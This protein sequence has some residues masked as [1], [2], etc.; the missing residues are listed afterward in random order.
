MRT[1]STARLVPRTPLDVLPLAARLMPA[2][3]YVHACAPPAQHACCHTDP[4]DHHVPRLHGIYRKPPFHRT[5]DRPH[6]SMDRRKKLE[7]R[8]V[9]RLL[10]D[11]G[12]ATARPPPHCQCWCQRRGGSSHGRR[13][14]RQRASGACN[15]DVGG[16]GEPGHRIR[17]G[18]LA[19]PGSV[20][21]L[22]T[23]RSV[24]VATD[25]G[26]GSLGRCVNV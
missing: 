20:G 15:F 1:P 9:A 16:Q 7:T 14:T 21:I 4:P 23:A 2:L 12:P 26:S 13:T 3:K 17:V 5:I 25:G 11:D 18:T 24:H 8:S 10:R 6:G 19:G 22:A